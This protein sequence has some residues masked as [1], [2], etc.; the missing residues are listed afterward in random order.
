MYTD[1]SLSE[2]RHT[3]YGGL[4]KEDQSSTNQVMEYVR[5]S[6]YDTNH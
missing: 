6:D 5:D 3:E 1:V 2:A 4:K